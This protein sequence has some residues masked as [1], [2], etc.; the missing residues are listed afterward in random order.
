[1]L[2]FF[3]YLYSSCP[4]PLVKKLIKRTVFQDHYNLLVSKQDA[5]LERLAVL[6]KEG[7]PKAQEEWEKSVTAWCEFL[8]ASFNRRR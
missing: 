4:D 5:L 8:P 2:L 1:M 7:F 6:T 3:Y